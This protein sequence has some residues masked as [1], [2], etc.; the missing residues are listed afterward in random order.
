MEYLELQELELPKSTMRDAAVKAT[1]QE[2]I[3][4]DVRVGKSNGTQI[5]RSIALFA[6]VSAQPT[7]KFKHTVLH[8][9]K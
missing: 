9:G 4:L 7:T 3:I 2:S 5:A 8:P 1:I 6:G